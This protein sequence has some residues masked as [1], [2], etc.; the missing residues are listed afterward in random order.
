[1]TIRLALLR[2]APTGLQATA[3]ESRSQHENRA[4]ALARL[5]CELALSLRAQV[6]IEGY[7]PAEELAGGW[8]ALGR[9]DVRFLP[10]VAALFDV[11]EAAE[12]RVSDA[13][14]LLGATTA[15]LGRFLAR[16]PAVWRVALTRVV[17][18]LDRLGAAIMGAMVSPLRGADGNVEFLL[19]ARAPGGPDAPPAPLDVDGLVAAAVEET[20]HR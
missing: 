12:W 10:A 17:D 20:G 5:R 8:Q 11:L 7:Q 18:A 3:V 4:R 6:S 9:R 19:H 13:A 2:H 15:S 14:R 16:D 1:M